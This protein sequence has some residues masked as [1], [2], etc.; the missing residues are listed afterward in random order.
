[1]LAC[2]FAAHR[3]HLA[4]QQISVVQSGL[5]DDVVQVAQRVLGHLQEIGDARHAA[6]ALGHLLQNL[7]IGQLGAHLKVVPQPLHHQRRVQVTEHGADVSGQ[8]T[9]ELLAHRPA[10]DG[11]FWEDFYD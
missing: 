9:G 11:D 8:L 4:R 5:G 1:M 2:T 6:Q 10:L 3:K 7:G